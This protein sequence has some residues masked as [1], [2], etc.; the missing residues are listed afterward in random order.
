MYHTDTSIPGRSE[1]FGYTGTLLFVTVSS[2]RGSLRA[3]E[4]AILEYDPLPLKYLYGSKAN[5]LCPGEVGDFILSGTD[6]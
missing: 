2:S 3:C 6:S 1:A 5:L 4:Y